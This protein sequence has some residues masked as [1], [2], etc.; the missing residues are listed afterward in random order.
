MS[1]STDDA[2]D[3]KYVASIGSHRFLAPQMGGDSEEIELYQKGGFHPVHLGDLYDGG[4]GSSSELLLS[5]RHSLAG[6]RRDIRTS[7]DSLY[8]LELRWQQCRR[9]WRGCRYLVTY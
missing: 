4:R 3:G 2:N 5:F 1:D 7:S 8:C 6:Y 9:L